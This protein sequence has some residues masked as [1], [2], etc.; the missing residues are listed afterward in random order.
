MFY[1]PSTH[2]KSLKN[3]DPHC[4]WASLLGSLPVFIAHS[5]TSNWQLPFLKQRKGETGR[6]NGFMTKLLERMMPDVR[7][8]PASFRIPGGR[9]S[10]R[11]TAPGDLDTCKPRFFILCI[12]VILLIL[13]WTKFW[14]CFLTAKISSDWQ[15]EWNPG[16]VI[17]YMYVVWM[18]STWP[19]VRTERFLHVR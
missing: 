10:D 14:F 17:N 13:L 4:S 6:R 11:A 8:E 16:I 7:I 5:F 12:S 3:I 1:G 18:L 9:G 19:D 2:F 15:I